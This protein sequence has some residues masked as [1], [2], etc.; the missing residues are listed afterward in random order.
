MDT[1]KHGFNAEY[2]KLFYIRKPAGFCV[3]FLSV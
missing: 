3:S 1:D 2:K